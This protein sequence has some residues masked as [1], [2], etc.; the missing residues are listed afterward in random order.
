MH[1]KPGHNKYMRID[2]KSGFIMKYSFL[3]LMAAALFLSSCT[4]VGIAGGVGAAAG[5]AAVQEGGISRAVSDAAIQ[6]QINDLWFRH[7]LKMFSKLDLTVNQ[8]RVLITGVVQDPQ[9]RVEA[10]RMAWQP[11][12]VVHVINEIKVAKSE[13]VVGFAKDAWISARI[14]SALVLAR[15]IESINYS[16][17]TV[18]GSVYL[19]GFAQDQ[20]ELE[21]VIGIART[22]ENVKQVVSYVKMAG[23]PEPQPV[24]PKNMEDV[25]YLYESDTAAPPPAAATGDPVTWDQESVYD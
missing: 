9:H 1:G 14:R 21:Q 19:M 25:Q 2:D 24:Q 10:V 7:D 12:G 20:A 22:I 23:T 17:D 18:Q 5:T 6:A 15:E 3:P 11:T 8:G 16:I 4:A 13:G